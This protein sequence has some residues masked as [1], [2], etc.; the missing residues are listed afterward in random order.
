MKSCVTGFLRTEYTKLKPLPCILK[1]AGHFLSGNIV[2][3]KIVIGKSFKVKPSAP[4]V[5]ASAF[6]NG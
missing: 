4:K 5:I 6:G 2:S 1:Y 3:G